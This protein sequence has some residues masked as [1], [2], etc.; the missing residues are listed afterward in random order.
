MPDMLGC[1]A[2]FIIPFVSFSDKSLMCLWMHWF[3]S[4]GSPFPRQL[5]VALLCGSSN[6]KPLF[7]NSCLSVPACRQCCL[8]LWL[9]VILQ[10]KQSLSNTVPLSSFTRNYRLSFLNLMLKEIPLRHMAVL[11]RKTLWLDPIYQGPQLDFLRVF[12]KHSIQISSSV[13]SDLHF[14]CFV[15]W[16]PLT[17]TLGFNKCTMQPCWIWQETGLFGFC[18]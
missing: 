18:Y 7:C 3:R 6:K 4:L 11:K 17:K 1:H 5:T 13:G 10:A 2:A 14:M 15:V 16:V 8:V 9:C 12:F